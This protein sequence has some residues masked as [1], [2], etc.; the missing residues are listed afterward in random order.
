MSAR[1]SITLQSNTNQQAVIEFLVR[2]V[3]VSTQTVQWITYACVCYEIPTI[4]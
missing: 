4:E 3:K 1:I 2:S